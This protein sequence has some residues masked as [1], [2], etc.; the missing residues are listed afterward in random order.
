MGIGY[1][2]ALVR[3]NTDGTLDTSFGLGGKVTTPIGI[4]NDAIAA[5]ALQSTGEIVAAGGSWANGR[6]TIAVARYLF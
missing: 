5:L 6:W 3:Y 2:F 4:N 1:D